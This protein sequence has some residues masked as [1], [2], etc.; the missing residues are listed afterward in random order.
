MQKK[1]FQ[2]LI[3]A[4]LDQQT[5]AQI[6]S[7]FLL[8]QASSTECIQQLHTTM[9][10]WALARASTFSFLFLQFLLL[11]CHLQ[12]QRSI[13]TQCGFISILLPEKMLATQYLL[14][15]VNSQCGM[16]YLCRTQLQMN[17]FL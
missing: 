10:E 17:G 11:E 7:D 6:I 12:V 3:K 2:G 14:I 1:H 4:H 9:L 5:S 16:K 15:I 8:N 13:L